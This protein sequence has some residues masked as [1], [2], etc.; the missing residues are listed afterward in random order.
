MVKS[1]KQNPRGHAAS[2]SDGGSPHHA[3]D[4]WV[5]AEAADTGLSR[6]ALYEAVRRGQVP[7]KR[8]GRRLRFRRQDL[9]AAFNS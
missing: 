8:L 4:L 6:R 7:A 1:K 2:E 5:A 3:D 9:D